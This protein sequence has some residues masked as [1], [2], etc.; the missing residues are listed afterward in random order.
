MS[1]LTITEALSEMKT[2]DA[3]IGKK[4]EFVS[5]YL[6]R[7]DRMRDPLEKQGGSRA[8]I[9]SELQSISDLSER[10]LQIRRAIQQANQR[11]EI[12]LEG[13]TRSIADWLVWRR[14]VAPGYQAQ[15]KAVNQTVQAARNDAMRKGL[16]VLSDP[17]AASTPNDVII[18]IDEVA[19][20]AEIERLEQTLGMLDGQLSLRNATVTIDI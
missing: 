1:K 19:L 20:A 6:Y 14:E 15:L 17:N 4:R 2:I 10:K 5:Q 13:S 8:I 11:V 16:S 3:R 18:N 9:A 12:T 7:Q